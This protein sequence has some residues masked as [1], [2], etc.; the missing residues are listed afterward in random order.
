MHGLTE[1]NIDKVV[2]RLRDLEK[3]IAVLNKSGGLK[4]FAKFANDLNKVSSAL[5]INTKA[6]SNAQKGLASFG[7]GAT[8]AGERIRNFGDR[9]RNYFSYRVV[10]D[11]V[12]QLKIAATEAVT[13]IGQYDQAL[14]DLQAITGAT[15]VEVSQMGEVIKEVASTTKFSAQEVA[16]GMRTLGQAGLTSSESIAAMQHVSNLATGTLTDMSTTV[17]LVTTAMRVFKLEASQSAMITDVF[18]N[19]VNGSKL[20]IDKLR[21][22]MNYVGPIAQSAGISLQEMSASMMTLANSGLRASTIGTGLR[23]VFAELVDPSNKL[24]EAADRAGVSLSQLDP[25]TNSLQEVIGNLGLVIED[26]GTAFDIFGKRGAAAVLA[27]TDG[28]GE[29]NTMLE[30]VR[31]SGTA[32]EMAEIQ[33]EGLAVSFKNLKDKLGNLAI[34]L[35]EAGLI[36]AFK[37][38]INLGRTLV[39]V[40]TSLAST[41]FGKFVLQTGLITVAVIALVGALG[42]LK[43]ALGTL[44]ST[45][46]VGWFAKL[47]S[48]IFRAKDGMIAYAKGTKAAT[49]GSYN[50]AAAARTVAVSFTA[51]WTA[52]WPILAVSAAFAAF[53]LIIK[54]VVWSVNELTSSAQASSDAAKILAD[55]YDRSLQTI[56]NYDTAMI[57][58]N[59]TSKEALDQ[60]KQIRES[61]LEVAQSESELADE[62]LAAAGSISAMT[63]KMYDSGEALAAF[64]EEA[65][66]LKKVELAKSFAE[67]FEALKQQ[68]GNMQAFLDFF[69][70]LFNIAKLTLDG[71][72]DLFSDFKWTDLFKM[73]VAA[74]SPFGLL[75]VGARDAK[76]KISTYMHDA[77]KAADFSDALSKGRVT[78]DEYAKYVEELMN[79]LPE[80]VTAKE[81]ILIDQFRLR[82]ADAISII[83]QVGQAGYDASEMTADQM[84][85]AA[86]SMDLLVGASSTAVGAIRSKFSELQGF[87]GFSNIIEKWDNGMDDVELSVNDIASSITKAGG[88]FTE[89]HQKRI[90]ESQKEVAAYRE[91]QQAIIDKYN[92]LKEEMNNATI[93]ANTGEERQAIAADYLPK[94]QATLKDANDLRKKYAK[95]S[96]VFEQEEL[97]KL[98]EAHEIAVVKINEKHKNDAIARTKAL[99]LINKKYVKDYTQIMEGVNASKINKELKKGLKERETAH[100]AHLYKISVLEANGVLT[101]EQAEI[102]KLNASI[103]YQDIRYTEAVQALEKLKAAKEAG[104]TVSEDEMNKAVALVEKEEQAKLDVRLKGMAKYGDELRKAEDKLDTQKEKRVSE[105]EKYE[106]KIT[107]VIEKNTV[108][109]EAA[110]SNYAKKIGTIEGTLA[111]KIISINQKLQQ[112]LKDFADKRVDVERASAATIAGLNDSLEDKLRNINQRGMSDKQ[113]DRDNRKAADKKLM[114]GQKA[115]DAARRSGDEDALERGKA[116][117]SQ[118]SGLY[119]GLDS[120]KKA[121]RGVRAVTAAMK[122][123]EGVGKDI[124]LGDIGEGEA[125]ARD[126]AAIDINTA[127]NLHDVKLIAAK[128]EYDIAIKATADRLTITLKAEDDRHAKVMSNIAKESA[129]LEAAIIQ[130]KKLLSSAQNEA[131]TADSVKPEAKTDSASVLDSSAAIESVSA[132]K[133]EA[134]EASSAIVKI[135]DT[136]VNTSNE[137]MSGSEI[138]AEALKRPPEEAREGYAAL[139]KATTDSGKVFYTTADTM[140]T[141]FSAFGKVID[142]E[143]LEPLAIVKTTLEAVSTSPTTIKLD[144]DTEETV[145]AIDEIVEKEVPPIEVPFVFTQDSMDNLKTTLG[146][147]LTSMHVPSDVE[148][149][150]TMQID[151]EPA[152]QKIES[153]KTNLSNLSDGTQAVV[154]ELDDS[155]FD[156]FMKKLKSV[157]EEELEISI[158]LSGVESIEALQEWME[159]PEL[160]QLI[161]GVTV[162]GSDKIDVLYQKILELSNKFITI[163]ADVVGLDDVNALQKAIDELD[164]KEITITVNTVQGKSLG[165]VIADFATG[166]M[167]Q[168]FAKGGDVFKRLADPLIR[169]GSGFKDDVPAMLTKGEFVHIPQAVSHYGI[170][171]MKSV[172]NLSFPKPAYFAAG[173]LAGS[174]GTNSSS[175]SDMV[176]LS[177]DFPTT[178]PPIN[179][180]LD[181]FQL[182]ELVSQIN[183]RNRMQS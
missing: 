84:I 50:L 56:Q 183:E 166:G 158:I 120:S 163:I 115:V 23:R 123:A 34:A 124:T 129:T 177:L 133:K 132:V 78:W 31:E 83:E 175:M 153:V 111:T 128:K 145:S 152:E 144:T 87:E 53:A 146:D 169:I 1:L 141:G 36:S 172:N 113:K 48:D 160:E 68:T 170:D 57:G 125:K 117:L 21:T 134:V 93:S 112:K 47:S 96:T 13:A 164:D 51:L 126:K 39:D 49:V 25:E 119:E 64:R 58:L 108:I 122:E 150:T 33:M 179:M 46:L 61:L 40:F 91:Q 182:D 15:S 18:A 3:A 109:R 27:L 104:T 167:A 155:Q 38:L 44:Q 131:Y 162:E 30:T 86:G 105:I 26:A 165:G 6:V 98:T 17:D 136:W 70:D 76:D 178:G 24:A 55:E 8:T 135:G 80:E 42:V 127:K 43:L 54:G 7:A 94:L 45:A 137:M 2:A 29:F 41:A 81:Q 4:N 74:G 9:I 149:S 52:L 11:F 14:K 107:K 72:K 159:D 66:R 22:S 110:A 106:K 62:A 142:S 79:K 102:D 174:L 156:S 20:T 82:S 63:G 71:I 147:E 35:G 60:N 143:V 69:K 73:S 118:A 97:D 154:L 65:E 100:K 75:V 16:E 92:T 168:A 114:E 95:E 101:H 161:V 32:A 116:L 139:I 88:T 85:I 148:I 5:N 12:M 171:F 77:S 176:N 99:L 67:G 140:A 89:E 173:G 121:E 157:S 138:A 10:A 90:E 37:M 181:S 130:Y 103:K 151:G 28:Q 19:A 180:Q 59:A